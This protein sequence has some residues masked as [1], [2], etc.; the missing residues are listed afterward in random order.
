MVKPDGVQ[1]GLIGDVIKSLEQKGYRLLA[2]KMLRLERDIAARHYAEHAE[3]HFFPH[4]V[5]YITSGPVVAMVWEGEGV[6]RGTRVI[7]GATNP[8]D[9][10]PGSLRGR[11][12]I[13]IQR[14]V[15]HASD[16]PESAEREIALYFTPGE[17]L[18]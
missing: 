6:I 2:L 14:N 13:D 1:R 9:A 7:V 5:Q 10:E 8:Q 15:V 16:S 3:K 18:E 12:A 4:L 17:I 11:F